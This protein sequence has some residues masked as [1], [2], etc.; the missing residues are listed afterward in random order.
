MKCHLVSR[1][2]KQLYPHLTG[3]D[4]ERTRATDR[5]MWLNKCIINTH[6]DRL[7]GFYSPANLYLSVVF[8]SGLS[9]RD[10]RH[11][12]RLPSLKQKTTCETLRA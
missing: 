4:R 8:C 5:H 10:D 1:C 3:R 9:Q 12:Q 2:S 11:Q 7:K 6:T